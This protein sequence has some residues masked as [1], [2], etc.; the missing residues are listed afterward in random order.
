MAMNPAIVRK[1]RLGLLMTPRYNRGLGVS[2]I[3]LSIEDFMSP[4]FGLVYP[5]SGMGMMLTDY[6]GDDNDPIINEVLSHNDLRLS[7]SGRLYFVSSSEG[8]AQPVDI[9]QNSLPPST[10]TYIVTTSTYPNLEGLNVVVAAAKTEEDIN[11]ALETNFLTEGR[12]YT[13]FTISDLVAKLQQLAKEH[14]DEEVED[15]PVAT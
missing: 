10:A 4:R 11:K 9:C 7:A 12:L 15:Q 14:A 6:A 1:G 2:I 3:D 13:W 8:A 5:L